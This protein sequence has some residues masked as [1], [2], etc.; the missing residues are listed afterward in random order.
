MFYSHYLFVFG[1]TVFVYRNFKRVSIKVW[2]LLDIKHTMWQCYQLWR[3]FYEPQL[4]H[5]FKR[6]SLRKQ[7]R[8]GGGL[9]K[10]CAANATSCLVRKRRRVWWTSWC[11]NTCIALP[12]ES[13]L[14]VKI[15]EFGLNYTQVYGSFG[16]GS[17]ENNARNYTN[18]RKYILS[19]YDQD[20]D[21]LHDG[22]CTYTHT[23][24][25]PSVRQ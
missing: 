3:H 11:I 18:A 25:I 5:A 8:G 2:I 9:R 10:R 4:L 14:N 23:V 15:K 6:A 21:G 16:T 20:Y 7:V 13:I 24:Q 19:T 1:L 12:Q 22:V 17:S